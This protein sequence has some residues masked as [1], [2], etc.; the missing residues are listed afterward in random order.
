MVK[1]APLRK[2]IMTDIRMETQP[3]RNVAQHSRLRV[4]TFYGFL[5]PILLLTLVAGI[6]IGSTKISWP[7]ILRV[8]EV[9]IL[10]HAWVGEVNTAQADRV[11]VWLIRIPRVLVAF[12]VGAGLAAS[13]VIMQALFR[14]PLAE[15]G[16]VGAG[17]GAVLGGVVAFV[18][19]WSA[20][21]VI[22]LPLMAMLGALAALGIVYAMATRGGT[23]PVATLLLSGVAASALLGAVSSLL[24]SINIVN[25]QIAQEIVFWM[26]GGLDA[27]TWTHVWLCAPFIVLG[28]IAALLQTRD[29]DLLQLGEETAAS[30]GVDVEASKRIL[31][32]TAAILTGS[33]VA[34]A[35]MVGFV[36][37]VVPHAIRLVLG[38]SN[39]V[40]IFASALTGGVF[41]IMCDILARTIHP[42]IEVR[43]GIVTALFGGPLF[44]VLLMRQ[45]RMR[46]AS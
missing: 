8:V 42:P 44:I 19:G 5:L 39:R 26:M 25:W 22:S 43:L 29:L 21:S 34:V 1:P 30:F 45:Y 3:G 16:L 33:A 7:A 11:I 14:N 27:R 32:L 15:P 35:G 6:G 40:L 37:L 36:G 4:G 41:L 24:L 31:T 2:G 38:P 23:T 9:K 28:L 46:A 18:T 13:G 20:A 17:A 10:P 12:F